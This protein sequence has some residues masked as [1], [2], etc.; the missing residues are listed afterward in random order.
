[1]DEKAL[2]TLLTRQ[3][4]ALE[5][6]AARGVKTPAATQTAPLLHGTTG[7]FG[8]PGLER[9]VITAYVRPVGIGGF[10]PHLPSVS[11]DPTFASLTGY[12]ATVGTR[13]T[14][15]CEDAPYG[16]IKGCNLHA[17]FGLERIDTGTIEMDKVMLRVRRSDFTDLVLMGEVLGMTGFTPSGLNQQQI[18]N[19]VTMS[20]MVGAG[21]QMERLLSQDLW[22]STVATAGFPGLDAQIATGQ[23]DADTNTACPALDSDVKSFAWND[24]CGT[25]LDIVEYLSMIAYYLMNNADTMGLSPVKWAIVMRPQLW[26]ELTACWPCKYNTN[27]CTSQYISQGDQVVALDGRENVS[28]R[29]RM[30]REMT[31]DIN[32]VTYPVILDSGI[33][34]YNSTNNANLL[35]GQF[36]SAIYFVPLTIRGNFPV[37]YIEYVDYRQA[38]PDR[39]LLQGKE[40][41]WWT[42]NGMYSWAIEQQ[43]WCY[44]LS[45][46]IEPRIVLRAPHLAGK[47]TYVRYSPLQH[48]REPYSDSVYNYDGGVSLR[49]S[50]RRYAIWDGTSR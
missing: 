33:Y 24:V 42:D 27:R 50:A 25:T 31:L 47:L 21:V 11:E 20:E 35:P 2:E 34:E 44:K 9:E 12:T 45:L 41:W 8:G 10:L 43:K 49:T 28:D 1:M 15:A 13:P 18:L 32:G 16:Y 5:A 29:D 48:L 17:R 46:K 3:T 39:A 30:R 36:A 7:I 22:Q 19:I 26:Y 6:L 4:A 38:A 14:N 23:V 40:D 37:T